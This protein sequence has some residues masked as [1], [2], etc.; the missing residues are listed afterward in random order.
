MRNLPTLDPYVFLLIFK[1]F[2]I[3]FVRGKST[4][5]IEGNCRPSLNFLEFFS[6]SIAEIWA[7]VVMEPPTEE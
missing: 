2:Q 4:F 5:F 1:L 3:E 6:K 7:D